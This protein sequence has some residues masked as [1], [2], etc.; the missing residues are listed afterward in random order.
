MFEPFA[1][2]RFE[3]RRCS[4]MLARRRFRCKTRNLSITSVGSWRRSSVRQIG[5][6]RDCG[7]TPTRPNVAREGFHQ[8]VFHRL[9]RPKN[10]Y[11]S[12]IG[13]K[14]SLPGPRMITANIAAEFGPSKTRTKR[15]TAVH[16]CFSDPSLALDFENESQKNPFVSE[17][18]SSRPWSNGVAAEAP[19]RGRPVQEQFWNDRSCF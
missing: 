9:R 15:L 10:F 17:K 13:R 8:W 19:V 14:P 5:E 16:E 12:L 18:N 1:G 6:V 7:A 11:E 3:L 2:N 4:A